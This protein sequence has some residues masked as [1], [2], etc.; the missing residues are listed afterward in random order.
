MMLSKKPEIKAEESKDEDMASMMN[1]QMIYFAPVFTVIIGISLPGGLSLY[2][3]TSTVLT[4][5]QQ[6]Y[7]FKR[8]QIKK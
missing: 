4:A 8:Q 1:K 6:L 2:W 3:L 7:I 5:L